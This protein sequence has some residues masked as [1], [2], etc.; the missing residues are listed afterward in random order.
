MCQENN[1][2]P[3]TARRRKWIPETIYR[4]I[5][6]QFSMIHRDTS[7]QRVETVYQIINGLIVRLNIIS[8]VA[9]IVLNSCV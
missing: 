5:E 4:Y 1:F 3:L 7:L 9:Q 8:F 6:K 2:H